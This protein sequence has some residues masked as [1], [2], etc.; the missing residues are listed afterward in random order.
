MVK[1][2]QKL[3]STEQIT[4]P[5]GMV[6]FTIIWVGQLVSLTGTQMTGFALTIWA[7]LLTGEATALALVGFFTFAPTVVLSPFAGA[8]VDRW[9][10][11]LVMMLSD[12]AAVVSTAVVF[13]LFVSGNLQIWHLYITGAFT[14]AFGAFQFPAY[15]A[16]VT[17][18]VSKKQYGRASGMLS[19]AQ[20]GST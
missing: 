10:R 14:G 6:A 9:S 4:R 8:L 3:T 5:T 11:K 7:W 18:M 1:P 2:N 12:L 13:L 20:F 16:A 19:M 17:T 15:S